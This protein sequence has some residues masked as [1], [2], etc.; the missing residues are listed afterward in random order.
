MLLKRIRELGFVEDGE[1][2]CPIAKFPIDSQK[3]VISECI[4]VFSETSNVA[5]KLNLNQAIDNVRILGC[6]LAMPL[7]EVHLVQQI[8]N[9][10]CR[11][12][13][14]PSQSL[15]DLSNN[16]LAF[17]LIILKELSGLFEV[18]YVGDDPKRIGEL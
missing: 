3:A 13:I 10:L 7:E 15:I 9:I 18:R 6:G 11:W 16:G 5:Q 1:E 4:A 8:T 12:L 2:L 17:Q 14:D